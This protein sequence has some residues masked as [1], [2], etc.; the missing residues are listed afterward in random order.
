MGLEWGCV[1][2]G[3]ATRGPRARGHPLFYSGFNRGANRD[4]PNDY[5]MDFNRPVPLDA[6]GRER[7]VRRA[8]D[9]R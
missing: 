3:V 1:V 7:G 5:G 6:R 4:Q 2:G 8:N 9:R